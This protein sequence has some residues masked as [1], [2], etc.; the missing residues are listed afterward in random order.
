MAAVA[1][2][3]AHAAEQQLLGWKFQQRAD[4]LVHADPGHLWT[5]VESIAARQKRQCMDVAAEVR[6]LSGSEPPI[7]GDEETHGRIEKLITALDLGEP[8]RAV[9]ARGAERPVKLHAMLEAP[10]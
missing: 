9:L 2:A 4:D 7:D 3:H 6:P 5:G 10:A 1:I 8:S